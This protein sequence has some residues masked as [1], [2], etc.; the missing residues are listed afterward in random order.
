[1]SQLCRKLVVKMASNETEKPK[2]PQKVFN[3]QESRFWQKQN[4]NK[5]ML[6]YEFISF[7]HPSVLAFAQMH[8]PHHRHYLLFR[9]SYGLQ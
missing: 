3:F 8:A 9:H 6:C 1:M 4:R 2:I 5:G 7:D